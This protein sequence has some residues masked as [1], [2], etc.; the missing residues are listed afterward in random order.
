[1]GR[2]LIPGAASSSSSSH[3]MMMMMMVM[4]IV[5]MGV[6][7][8]GVFVAVCSSCRW[9]VTPTATSGDSLCCCCCY[10]ARVGPICFS[11]SER[12]RAREVPVQK[13]SGNAPRPLL[14]L[15]LSRQVLPMDDSR[16]HTRHFSSKWLPMDDSRSH[17]RRHLS[18]KRSLWMILSLPHASSSLSSKN[19][20]AGGGWAG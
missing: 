13:E 3:I 14:S 9:W 18:S 2:N 5:L 10:C 16:S 17:T 15:S 6:Q 1:M 4:M 20:P 8:T 11:A 7:E 19:R 12:E